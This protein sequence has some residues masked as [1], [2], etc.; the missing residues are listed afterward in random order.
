MNFFGIVARVGE[1]IRRGNEPLIANKSAGR[2][3]RP[4]KKCQ[5]RSACPVT[6][7]KYDHLRQHSLMS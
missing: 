7:T 6:T 4:L 3:D 1:E 2:N 5:M